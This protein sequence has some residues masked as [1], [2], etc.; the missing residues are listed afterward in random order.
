MKQYEVRKYHETWQHY[1]L[2]KEQPYVVLFKTTD[3]EEA[4]ERAWEEF[5]K[6]DETRAYVVDNSHKIVAYNVTDREDMD[7]FEF[8]VTY[9]PRPEAYESWDDFLDLS[10]KPVNLFGEQSDFSHVFKQ[11]EPERYEKLFQL[12]RAEQNIVII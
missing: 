5:K 10:F 4:I 12:W 11:A 1:V 8:D 7:T 9:V 2:G 6:L 3:S